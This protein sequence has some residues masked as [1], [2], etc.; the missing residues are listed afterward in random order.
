MQGDVI[1]RA[2]VA[3]IDLNDIIDQYFCHTDT[4]KKRI[5][6]GSIDRPGA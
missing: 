6:R 5:G 4:S 2:N 3:G 1:D